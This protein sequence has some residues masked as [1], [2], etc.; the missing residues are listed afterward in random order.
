[1]NIDT[2]KMII[3]IAQSGSISGAADQLGYAQSNISARVHQLEADLETSL[4]YRTNRGVILTDD[5]NKFYKKAVEIVNL[6]EDTI[7]QLQ[8]PKVIEGDLKIGT[9]QAASATYLPPIL[10]QYHQAFP[11]VRLTIETGNPTDNIDHVLDYELNGAVIG[12]NIENPALNFIP[13]TKEKLCI[14]SVTPELPDLKTA[15]FLVFQTGCVYRD[16]VDDWLKAQGLV[17]HEAIEFNYLDAVMASACAGLGIAIV[18]EKVADTFVKNHLLYK[19]ELPA[20]FSEIQLRFIYRKDYLINKPFE[21]FIN[22]L[23]NN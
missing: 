17:M 13:L 20:D 23:K 2:F 11:K 19:T 22:I 12:E 16:V 6:T 10:T 9:L 21:E 1:M 15:P 14:V 7:N 4:F 8:H 18:P 5:G 3:A